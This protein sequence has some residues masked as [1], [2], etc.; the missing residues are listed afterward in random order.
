MSLLDESSTYDYGI[1][2]FVI[3]RF[4]AKKEH[5]LNGT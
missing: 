2:K 5:F 3:K 1:R 4:K